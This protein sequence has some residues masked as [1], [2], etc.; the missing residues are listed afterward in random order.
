MTQKRYAAVLFDLLTGLL[1]SW[2][3]WNRVAGSEEAGRRWNHSRG[4]S[5]GRATGT[6]ASGSGGPGWRRRRCAKPE[7]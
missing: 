6:I 4:T 3:V 5:S 7:R 1:D 2:T